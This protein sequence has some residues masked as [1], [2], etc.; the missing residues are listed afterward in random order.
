MIST[1]CIFVFYSESGDIS[2][3]P[4]QKEY[5]VVF[6]ARRNRQ[7]FQYDF[8]ETSYLLTYSESDVCDDSLQTNGTLQQR[9]ITLKLKRDRG[10][11]VGLI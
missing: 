1:I 8:Q 7:V 9:R 10:I 4:R 3:T 5:A 11:M 6:V 2:I